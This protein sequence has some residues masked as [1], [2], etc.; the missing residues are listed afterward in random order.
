[1]EKVKT[2]KVI[3][4]EGV[5]GVGKTAQAEK[6]AG[7][8][9]VEYIKGGGWQ[10]DSSLAQ[11]ARREESRDHYF[12]LMQ[13]KKVKAIENKLRTCESRGK[14][15]AVVDRFVLVDVAH[16]LSKSWDETSGDFPREAKQAAR[17]S[18][19]KFIPEET[20]GIVLD[21]SDKRVIEGRIRSRL[22]QEGETVSP[23][24]GLSSWLLQNGYLS[25]ADTLARF[26]AKRE[27][28]SWCARELGW[29]II[30]GEGTEEE[31]YKKIKDFLKER[32]IWPEGQIRLPEGGLA[33]TKEAR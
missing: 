32:G 28:W 6:L 7:N 31:V 11:R 23:D 4:I 19:G 27:A 25:E 8:L 1:M 3:V 18:L 21:I 15:I 14:V 10:R 24:K 5:D 22:K 20:L 17:Q 9:G 2:I 30:N 26:K 29:G 33:V 13:L 16:I 12:S